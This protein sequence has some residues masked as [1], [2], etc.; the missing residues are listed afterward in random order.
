MTEK[1]LMLR[2]CNEDMTS[3]GGFVWPESGPV[4]APDWDP[5]PV[6]G[7]GL[8]GLLWGEGDGALLDWGVDARWLVV[9]VDASEI[10]CV[11]GKVKV[12]R[13]TVVH[14]GDQ[15]SATRY[16]AEH[17]GAGRA[18]VGGIAT[19]GRYGTATAG[20]EGTAT[21]GDEGTATA[22]RYGTATAGDYDGTATAGRGGTATAGRYGTAIAGYY[23]I[24]TAG[25]CGT[26]TAGDCGT[27]TAGFRGTAIAGDEG[28]ATAG[29]CGVIQ[30]EWWD[31]TASRHRITTAYVGEDGVEPGVA[32]CC[33]EYGKLRRKD[34]GSP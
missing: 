2:T 13:G 11:G 25:D 20:D 17:G 27:A 28:T 29:R 10:V 26:A 31:H 30:I 8:H 4:E 9:E 3:H 7:G 18:I 6:C 24:A 34:E 5:D 22:G 33:D 23:G 19:A 16:L 12:P 32:Y 1:A 21:A 15:Q 14:C